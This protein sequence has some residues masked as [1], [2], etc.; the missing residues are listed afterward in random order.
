M[1]DVAAVDYAAGAALGGAFWLTACEFSQIPSESR[2]PME[3][4]VGSLVGTLLSTVGKAF[5]EQ[6]VCEIF[7]GSMR[8]GI[9]SQED[10]SLACG[11]CVVYYQ[12]GYMFAGALPTADEAGVFST[13]LSLYRRVEPSPLGADWWSSTCGVVDVT[14]ARLSLLWVVFAHARYPRLCSDPTT[15]RITS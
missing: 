15:R 3:K 5:T 1:C 6:R 2:G 14:S 7:T 11:I 10:T 9:L 12:I 4:L 8:A 13:V